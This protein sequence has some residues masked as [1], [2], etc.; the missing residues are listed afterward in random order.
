MGTDLH[1]FQLIHNLLGVVVELV[2]NRHY[3]HL[4]RSQPG[5]EGT[6]VVFDQ[7]ADEPFDG[8]VHHTVDHDRTM[9][10]A[11][12]PGVGQVKFLRQQHIQLD[13]AALP[14]PADGILQMEVDLRAVKGAVPFVDAVL[15]AEIVHGLAQ[16]VGGHFPRSIVAH[17]VVRTGGQFCMVGQAEGGVHFVEQTDGFLDHIF[18]LVG[19]HEDVGIV[20]G[21]AAHTEQAVQGAG[22]FMT[23]DQAQ[24]AHPQR[25]FFVGVGFVGI[26]QHAAGAVHGFD[27]VIFTI[28]FGEV[29]VFFVVIPVTGGFPQLPVHDHGGHD[30]LVTVLAMDFSPVIDQ[31]IPDDHAVRQEEGEARAVIAEH[32]QAQLF[33]QFPVIPFFSFFHHVQVRFQVFLAGKSR[34][35]DPLQHLVVFITPPVGTG[36]AHQFEGFHTA[37]GRAVRTGAQVGEIALGIGTDHSIFRQVFDQFHLVG[38]I[39]SL[40]FGQ[41]LCPGQFLADQRIVGFDD[42]VHFFFNGPQIFRREHVVAVQVIVKAFFN[43]RSDGKFGAGEQVLD[44]LGHHMGSRMADGM[45]PFLAVRG[46]EFHLGIMIQGIH[47]ILVFAVHFGQQGLFAQFLI[48]ALSDIMQADTGFEFSHAAIRQAY[49]DVAHCYFLLKLPARSGRHRKKA[50]PSQGRAISSRFHPY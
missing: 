28:D 17:G 7:D 15:Q 23:M 41:S 1:G 40:E 29:H 24:F 30:F 38:L 37:G 6:G 25:Q 43:G 20:L 36:N 39:S 14:G 21:E 5:R 4:F 8:P 2:G 10:L 47:Q 49:F 32:E 12:F 9:F 35:I 31:G 45:Q 19:H 44:S 27:G 34:T 18:D 13:G 33:A 11:I 48:Q 26:D 16:G 3:A 46:D 42:L 50:R 22:Q